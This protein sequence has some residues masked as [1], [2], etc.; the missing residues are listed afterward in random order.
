MNGGWTATEW[1][2]VLSALGVGA[3]L[4]KGGEVLWKWLGGRAGRERDAVAYERNR[5][6]EA[7]GRADSLDRK[8]DIETKRR[9]AATEYAARLRRHHIEHCGA[10]GLP[11]WPTELL[12]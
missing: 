5:A 12:E 1:A 11:E 2:S 4:L 7:D 3:I 10:D 8:L 9:R 6:D